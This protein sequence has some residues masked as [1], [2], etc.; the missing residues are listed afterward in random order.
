MAAPPACFEGIWLSDT[1]VWQSTNGNSQSGVTVIYALCF[2]APIQI[3]V[4][5]INY[6]GYGTTPPC[7]VYRPT[8]HPHAPSGQIEVYD[9]DYN[10][11]FGTAG[12][13]VINPDASCPCW[14]TPTE[15]STW[16]KVKALYAE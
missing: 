6:F 10:L 8:A 2:G 9:C 15:Q 16:G 13:A 5:T 12:C 7:C 11:L 3:H 4:L 1:W 14:A